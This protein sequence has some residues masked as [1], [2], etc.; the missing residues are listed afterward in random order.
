M[1]PPRLPE[2]AG[3]ECP[4]VEERHDRSGDHDLLGRHAEEA[5]EPGERE[6]A[7][8]SSGIGAGAPDEGVEGQQIEEPHQRLRPL[9]DIGHR[10][11]LQRMEGPEERGRE[12]GQVGGRAGQ[13]NQGPPEDPEEDEP[14]EDV[15]REVDDVVADDIG[16]ADRVVGGEREVEDRPARHGGV[17]RRKEGRRP[18]PDRRVVRDGVDVV[19]DERNRKGPAVGRDRRKGDGGRGRGNGQAARAVRRGSGRLA[20]LGLDSG[21]HRFS[22]RRGAGSAGAPSGSPRARSPRASGGAGRGRGPS[23]CRRRA[24]SARRGRSRR[25]SGRRRTSG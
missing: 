12:G 9:D 2:T 1:S 13:P 8:P 14:G 10:L 18:M 16:A 23:S 22:P 7:A 5:G 15:D 25:P 20:P 19:E 6:P 11:G 24:A 4:V 17:G 3:E 21:R